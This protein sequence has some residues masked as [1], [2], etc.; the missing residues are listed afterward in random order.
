MFTCPACGAADVAELASCKCGAD[1]SLLQGLDGLAD[2]WFN[3]AVAALKA[4]ELERAVEWLAACCAARPD[5][6]P[7]LRALAKAWARLGRP[8]AA[9]QAL[10]RARAAAPEAAENDA[11]AAAIE[12]RESGGAEDGPAHGQ[13]PVSK[14]G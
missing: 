14:I 8:N 7:A 2:A 1:L 13:E 10:Y 11:I 12:G 3:R 4:D 6:A 9:R 5:D